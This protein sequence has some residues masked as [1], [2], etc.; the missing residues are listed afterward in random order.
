MTVSQSEQMRQALTKF[1]KEHDTLIDYFAIIG[2][3]SGQLRKVIAEILACQNERGSEY[4]DDANKIKQAVPKESTGQYR[5][6][7]PSVLERFPQMDRHR[8]DFP[9]QLHS[10]FFNA[11][12]TVLASRERMEADLAAWFKYAHGRNPDEGYQTHGY[13]DMQA[14]HSYITTHIFYEDLAD[15]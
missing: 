11:R 12:E 4:L 3:D 15:I 9:A 10:Y 7:R 2:F 5:I 8:S 13:T 6:L 14:R 1:D